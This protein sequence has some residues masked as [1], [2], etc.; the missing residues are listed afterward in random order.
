MDG[1]PFSI[2]V[3]DDD[4]D[5]RVLIDEAFQQIG[6]ESEVKKFVDGKSLLQYLEKV[7]PA[8]Y[9]SLIVLDN[10][11]PELEATDILALLKE[12]PAYKSIPVVIY[13]TGVSPSKKEKLLSQGAYACFEKGSS[14]QDLVRMAQELKRLSQSNL[15]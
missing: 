9:P 12:N 1:L 15:Q 14:M 11:L 3:V 4:P 2:L 5:D 6:Y 10:T 7:E 13:T 8:L